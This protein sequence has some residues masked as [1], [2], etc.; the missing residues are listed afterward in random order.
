[1][2]VH[3]VANGEALPAGDRRTHNWPPARAFSDC[4]IDLDR[5]ELPGGIAILEPF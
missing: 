4:S 2:S 5:E 1:M 3:R